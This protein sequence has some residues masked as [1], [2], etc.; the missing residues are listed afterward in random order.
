MAGAK[1]PVP[2]NHAGGSA[3]TKN[4]KKNKQMK[5]LLIMAAMLVV[6]A[7]LI[8]WTVLLMRDRIGR[9]A[10]LT[11]QNSDVEYLELSSEEPDQTNQTAVPEFTEATTTATT[12]ESGDSTSSVTTTATNASAP[13]R[14]TMQS[15]V[16]SK[17]PTTATRPQNTQTTARQQTTTRQQ[18]NK[19]QTR[20]NTTTA[21]SERTTTTEAQQVTPKSA[22]TE[23]QIP[24]NELLAVYLGAQAQGNSAYYFDVNGNSQPTVVVRK[25]K[26]YRVISPA[27]H[28]SFSNRLGGTGGA[29]EH[30]WQTG[31]DFMLKEYDDGD[32]Y[33]Y[34]SS[35]GDNNLILGYYNCRTADNVW[36]RLH[37]YQVGV[38]WQAEYHIAY[39][40]IRSGD[41]NWT[42]ACTDTFDAA[43]AY[44]VVAA[45]FQ[46]PLEKELRSHNM[47]MGSWGEYK[48]VKANQQA[49]ALWEKAGTHNS[50]FAPQAGETCGAVT[51]TGTVTLYSAANPSSAAAAMLPAG[52][53]LSIPKTALPIGGNM[54][55]AQAKVNGAWV[56]GY[57]QPEH[58]IAWSAD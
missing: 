17:I 16:F 5:Q 19:P 47:A 31:S 40:N 6:C 55:Q 3:K 28:Y 2:Q 15:V 12:A 20:T 8:T 51:G 33:I 44:D 45:D 29:E 30:P 11:E 25:D 49:D 18:T 1:R 54:V 35:S 41:G 13:P 26:E 21:A 7:V 14:V 23:A 27:E 37:Y 48:E 34:Y 56:T 24:F 50:G 43:S 9:N 32:R 58:V 57:L 42:E 36:A 38:S 46:Q 53:L 22:P 39:G 52:T 10:Q 4:S